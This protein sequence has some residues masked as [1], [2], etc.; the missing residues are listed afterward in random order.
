MHSCYFIYLC[1]FLPLL[2][3]SATVFAK[4]T[5]ADAA[6]AVAATAAVAD[7]VAAADAAA[8]AAAIATEMYSPP[9]FQEV[10]LATNTKQRPFG[11]IDGDDGEQEKL[12]TVYRTLIKVFV[13]NYFRAHI[14]SS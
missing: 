8:V 4:A 3:G 11:F 9:L 7:A 1:C 10:N 12:G 6:A 2:C 5:A 13:E 14:I